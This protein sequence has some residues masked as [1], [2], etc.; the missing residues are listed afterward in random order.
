MISG[1]EAFLGPFLPQTVFCIFRNFLS[2]IVRQPFALIC[3]H[4]EEE[5]A[6]SLFSM[7][8]YPTQNFTISALPA[9]YGQAQHNQLLLR[10]PQFDVV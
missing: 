7:G 8:M 10:I 3:Q 1:Y 4:K 5:T 2:K 6:F 9:C